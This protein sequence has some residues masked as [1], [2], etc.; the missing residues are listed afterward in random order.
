M[1]FFIPDAV[2][3]FKSQFPE[4]RMAMIGGEPLLNKV[5]DKAIETGIYEGI[6]F[7]RWLPSIRDVARTFNQSK[8]IVCASLNEGVP[9]VIPEALACGVPVVSTKVGIVLEIIQNSRNGFIVD[10]NVEALALNIQNIL[11]NEKLRLTMATCG[12]KPFSGL[13]T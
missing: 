8:I 12:P 3:I 6:D 13:I 10:W 9:R 5:K 4:F 2:R 11:L 1:F 7:L